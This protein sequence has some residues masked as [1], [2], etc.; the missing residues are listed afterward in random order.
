[1]KLFWKT[2]H[3]GKRLIESQFFYQTNNLPPLKIFSYNPKLFLLSTLREFDNAFKDNQQL[4]T[5]DIPLQYQGLTMLKLN[6]FYQED[7]IYFESNAPIT[8]FLG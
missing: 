7:K 1:M 5:A 4:K 6:T 3:F 8:L 2:Q